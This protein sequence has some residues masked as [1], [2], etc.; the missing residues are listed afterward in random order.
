[1]P[2]KIWACSSS[3]RAPPWHGGG[4]GFDPLQVH[5]NCGKMS[6][7]I[8]EISIKHSDFFILCDK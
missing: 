3:G 6:D 2:F 4:R 1:M 7:A 5:Q 8:L